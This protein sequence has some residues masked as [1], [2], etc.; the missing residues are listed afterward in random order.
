MA[1]LG[2]QLLA[3][4]VGSF[5]LQAPQPAKPPAAPTTATAPQPYN[6]HKAPSAA[7]AAGDTRPA[8]AYPYP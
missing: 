5:A 8:S 7:S 4:L 3:T 2:S 6:P 1:P